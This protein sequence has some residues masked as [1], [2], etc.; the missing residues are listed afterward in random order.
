MAAKLS[1]LMDTL[2]SLSQL[3]AATTHRMLL[4]TADEVI[5]VKVTVFTPSLGL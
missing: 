1:Q 3:P 2:L 5:G 4:V